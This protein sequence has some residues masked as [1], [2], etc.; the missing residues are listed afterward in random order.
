MLQDDELAEKLGP[1]LD[2]FLPRQRWFG[3]DEAGTSTIT[4]L[5]VQRK[6]PLLAWVELDTTTSEGN[7]ATYQ[8]VVGGRPADSDKKFLEGK[9]RVTLGVVDGMIFYDALV[10][11]ELA[12]DVLNTVAPDEAVEVARPLVVEQSNTSVVYD[13][14]LIMK[15]FRRL[16]PEP[17]PDVEINRVLGERGFPHVVPQ[18]AVLRRDGRDVAVVRDYLLASSDAWQMAQTSLRDL[19]NSRLAP[20]EAGADFGPEAVALGEITGLLD[21]KSVV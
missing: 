10:D 21:R 12:I 4:W 13:E 1:L 20:D 6:D 9:D 11:P 15:F 17:N 19:L 18:R 14:R 3:G 7:T 16:H 8:I 2:A 5:E